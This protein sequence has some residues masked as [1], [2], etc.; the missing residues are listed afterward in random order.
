[1]IL[2]SGFKKLTR[3]QLPMCRVTVIKDTF[4]SLYFHTMSRH[5]PVFKTQTFYSFLILLL[6]H[7]SEG[8]K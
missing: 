1:M 6:V 7:A 3:L 8:I 4:S 2:L 5:G